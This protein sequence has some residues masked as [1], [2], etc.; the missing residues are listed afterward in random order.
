MEEIKNLETWC[1]VNNLFNI[2]KTKALKVNFSTKQMR[3]YQPPT[4]NRTPVETV[5]SF[6]CSYHTESDM[7]L[8][9]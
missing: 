8:P 5:D 4:M 1:Q 6:R 3:N 9:F 2:S 7:I